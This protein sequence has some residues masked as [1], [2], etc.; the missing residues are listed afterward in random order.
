M[1]SMVEACLRRNKTGEFFR[2]LK[3]K[4]DRYE[5]DRNYSSITSLEFQVLLDSEERHH[6]A[7]VYGAIDAIGTLGGV[8]EIILWC[9]MIIYGSF[10]RN[11]YMYSIINRLTQIK[12][13]HNIT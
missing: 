12:K 4:Q 5:Q 1:K 3:E 7:K 10:R 8:H 2:V 9:I 11:V 13:H 6:S